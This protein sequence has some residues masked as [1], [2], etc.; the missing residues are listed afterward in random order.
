MSA[1]DGAVAAAP[2]RVGVIGTGRIG[3]LHAELLQH[4]VAGARVAMVCDAHVPSA[5]TAAV[6][7]GVPAVDSADELIGSAEVDAVAI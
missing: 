4:R 2:L 7:L 3:R 1:L 6:E 5:L